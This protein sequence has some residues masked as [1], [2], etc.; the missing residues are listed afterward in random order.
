MAQKSYLQ[1]KESKNVIKYS[2]AWCISHF[3]SLQILE[4]QAYL[5]L[6]SGCPTEVIMWLTEYKGI[7]TSKYCV[8]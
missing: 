8:F 3:A 1:V 5:H 7:K 6:L 4:Y 2:V